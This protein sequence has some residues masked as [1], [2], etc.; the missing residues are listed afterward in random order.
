MHVGLD[1]QLY[2][3]HFAFGHLAEDIVQPDRLL[4][5]QLDVALLGLAQFG[6]FPGLALVGHNQHIVSGQRST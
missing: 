4:L 3:L 5:R 6:H 1:Q 2:G